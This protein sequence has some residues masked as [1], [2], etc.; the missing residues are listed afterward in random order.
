M[1]NLL[2]IVS[3]WR[4]ADYSRNLEVSKKKKKKVGNVGKDLE[5]NG[6]LL[7]SNYAGGIWRLVAGD[8]CDWIL[9][10]QVHDISMACS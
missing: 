6:C 2:I 1:Y 8:H 9:M 7:M 5:I 4:K 3:R 10:R